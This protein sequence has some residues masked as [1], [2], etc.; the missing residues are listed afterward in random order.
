MQVEI[1]GAGISGVADVRDDLALA[2]RLSHH[3]CIGIALEVRVVE[4]ELLVGA[5][6]IDRGA[7]AFA[8][9]E[10]DDFAVGGR[11][12]SSACGRGNIDRVVDARL[13]TRVG[14]RV[15]QLIRSDANDRNDQFQ[16]SDKTLGRR[17]IRGLTVISRS[18]RVV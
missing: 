17:S 18:G 5:E 4:H 15:R 6:L 9:E 3:Q 10:F 16:S 8:L 12:D 7:A 14:K 1:S 2:H 13:R 11:D